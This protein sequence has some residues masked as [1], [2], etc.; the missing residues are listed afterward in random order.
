MVSHPSVT[1]FV[2]DPFTGVKQRLCFFLKKVSSYANDK[3][4]TQ[5]LGILYPGLRFM[6]L[7]FIIQSKDQGLPGTR[8]LSGNGLPSAAPAD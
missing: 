3:V 4:R 6:A 2:T 1:L 5:N 8:Q 7:F